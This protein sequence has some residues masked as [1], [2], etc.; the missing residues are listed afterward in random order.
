MD[1]DNS[2]E[3]EK[4]AEKPEPRPGIG[5]VNPKYLLS[6]LTGLLGDDDIITTEV[7]RTRYGLQTILVSKSPGPL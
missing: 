5:F 2:K 7:D 4:H 1:K 6:V 3:R